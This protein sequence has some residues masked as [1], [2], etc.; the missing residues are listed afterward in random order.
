MTLS[1]LDCIG[2]VDSAILK[3]K[4]YF[5]KY[6]DTVTDNTF[7]FTAVKKGNKNKTLL[8]DAHIDEV[9]MIVTDI[10]N[11]FLTV[12]ACGGIDLRTLSA[13]KVKV[14]GKKDIDGVFVST[15]PHLSAEKTVADSISEIKID[16]GIKNAADYISLGDYVTYNVKPCELACNKITGKAIDNR[17]G[18]TVLILLAEAIS[19]KQ[20]DTTVIFQ[21]SNMEELGLRGAVTSSFDNFSDEAIVLD[22]SFGS[23][24]DVDKYSSKPLGSGAMIGVSPVLDYSLTEKIKTSAKNCSAKHTFE[25][26]GGKTGTNADVISKTKSGIKTALVS[27]PI[28]NM[29]TDAEVISVCDI[30]SAVEILKEYIVNG[31]GEND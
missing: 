20:L 16:T 12:S 3:A 7:G 6:C 22:V 8:L 18:V 17:A 5:N 1:E 24:P 13:K 21:L 14:H 27:V 11:E 2:S 31:G 29:H 15:P 30:L 19:Q 10:E 9:G 4:E 25:V 28:R 23:A 26:M